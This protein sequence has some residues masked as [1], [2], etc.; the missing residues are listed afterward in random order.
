MK[1]SQ[2]LAAMGVS[3]ELAGST[4]R[5]S[6]GPDTRERDVDRFLVEWRR[7]RNRAK[8]EAA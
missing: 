3:A 5:V 7:L 1:P 4:I 2:V 6:F 8:A